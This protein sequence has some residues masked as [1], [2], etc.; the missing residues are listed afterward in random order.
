MLIHTVAD[1]GKS[2]GVVH[3]FGRDSTKM[4][5]SVHNETEKRH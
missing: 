3:F 2:R 4:S 5:S 1:K